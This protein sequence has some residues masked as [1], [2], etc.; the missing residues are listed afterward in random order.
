[1]T[2]YEH[3]DKFTF[4]CPF[5][6]LQSISLRTELCYAHT[7]RILV[8]GSYFS[9]IFRVMKSKNYFVGERF[10]AGAKVKQ[11][12][13]FSL[14]QLTQISSTPG[15]KPL[16]HSVINDQLSMVTTCKSGVYH[17]L[18]M[19]HV[20]L[21]IRI[22]FSASEKMSPWFFKLLFIR[23]AT[24]FS[25]IFCNTTIPKLAFTEVLI[26]TCVINYKYVGVEWN[27][28]T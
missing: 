28:Y 16:Y 3:R 10:A 2:K 8:T 18:T 21:E 22:K 24:E 14:Q 23:T 13:T 26:Y 25:S 27:F 7:T 19:Y 6:K 17:M 9:N 4:A 20:Y 12:V 5:V 1:M 11:A 15:F